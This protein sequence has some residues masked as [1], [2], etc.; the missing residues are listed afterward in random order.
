M[1]V[2]DGRTDKMKLVKLLNTSHTGLRLVSGPS[3][4]RPGGYSSGTHMRS[5]VSGLEE[6]R[7]LGLL[8]AFF[9]R[10]PSSVTGDWRPGQ[11][12][13]TLRSRGAEGQRHGLGMNKFGIGILHSALRLRARYS[14]SLS[15]SLSLEGGKLTG[16]LQWARSMGAACAQ[17]RLGVHR[18]RT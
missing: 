2:K 15:H 7:L 8:I 18:G 5:G 11:Y 16:L 3:L 9:P 6:L 4:Q 1:C 12:P 17:H 13:P 14:S 10:A